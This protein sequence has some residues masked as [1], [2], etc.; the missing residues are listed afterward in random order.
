MLRSGGRGPAAAR[1]TG[2]R[3]VGE[4]W[5]VFLDDDVRVSPTWRTD[6]ARDLDGASP[7]TGGIQGVLRVPQPADRRPTDWERSTAGLERA[8]WVT[9]DMA[10]RT[11]ALRD[12]GG[13]DERFPA[14]SGRTRTWRCGC[15]TPGGWSGGGSGA[16][17]T[18]CGP[19]TGGCRCGCSGATP[20]T[21]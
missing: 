21:R 17:T 18:P 5:T 6:L 8:L 16:P 11:D 4:P 3:A 14:P 10:Y 7:D 19:P 20:T 9:A 13:F 1:N 12:A 15:W 2:L